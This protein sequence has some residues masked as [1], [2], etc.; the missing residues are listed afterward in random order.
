MLSA[1]LMSR[2]Y[3][4]GNPPRRPLSSSEADSVMSA[5]SRP[6]FIFCSIGLRLETKRNNLAQVHGGVCR[7]LRTQIITGFSMA[8]RR[9]G[10]K[11]NKK[12]ALQ[13]CCVRMKRPHRFQEKSLCR[14]GTLK[15]GLSGLQGGETF[16]KRLALPFP[17]LDFTAV[18]APTD[19][20]A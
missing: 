7:T 6:S 13:H 12:S 9:N 3:T 17:L 14:T 15:I 19:Q 16:S 11:R 5:C 2:R 1:D 4:A 8:K 10:G 18:S 20:L